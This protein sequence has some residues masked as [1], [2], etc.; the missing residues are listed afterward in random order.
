MGRALQ[1]ERKV[2]RAMGL[3]SPREQPER[4]GLRE[5][6]YPVVHLGKPYIIEN[7]D[8]DG[9]LPCLKFAPR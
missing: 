9:R 1:L 6:R 4:S 2:M 5:I 8:A 7:R 3:K